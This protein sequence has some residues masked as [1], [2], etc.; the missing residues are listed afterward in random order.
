MAQHTG[1]SREE[2]EEATKHDH[3]FTAKESVQFGLCDAVITF[4]ELVK[5]EFNHG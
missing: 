4:S 1:R 3:Y 5:G 2:I